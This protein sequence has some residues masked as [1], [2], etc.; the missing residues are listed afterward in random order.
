MSCFDLLFF[1]PHFENQSQQQNTVYK[2]AIY[3]TYIAA[4]MFGFGF[5]L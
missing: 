3:R 2:A 4:R 5:K 1:F